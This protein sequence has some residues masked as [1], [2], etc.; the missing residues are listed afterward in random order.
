MPRCWLICLVSLLPATLVWTV[1]QKVSSPTTQAIAQNRAAAP[2]AAPQL[3]SEEQNNISV[4]EAVNQSVVHITTRSLPGGTLLLFETSMEGSGSGSVLNRQGH[5][6]TNYHVIEGARQIQVTLHDGQSY[7][8]ELVG[9]DPLN[10][11]AVLHI[12]APVER[13]QPIVWGDSAQLK[14]GQKIFAIGNPFGLERTLTVGIISS[15]NRTLPSRNGRTMKSIIQIDAALNQGNS[16]GPL[17]NSAGQFVGMNTA[18]ASHSG[19]NTGVGFSI[20]ANTIKRV[21]PELIQNGH[22]TRPD[23]GITRVYQTDRGLMIARMTPGGPAEQ[24]GLQGFRLLRRQNR[25]GPFVFDETRLDQSQADLIVAVDQQKIVTVDEFLTLIDR[26]KP[27]DQVTITVIRNRRK[28]DIPVVL[29][30]D[31]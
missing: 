13:L 27:G 3:T 16:G 2:V 25:R 8:A 21:I 14:I 20:S 5:I 31:G 28:L 4:Y 11:I 17:L 26:K 30:S 7:T 22:I 9:Q 6:L 10:D 12:D 29:G 18:I 19:E 24:A 15:L 1:S 23:I